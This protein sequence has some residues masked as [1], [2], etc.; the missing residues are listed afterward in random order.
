MGGGFVDP[1]DSGGFSSSPVSSEGMPGGLGGPSSPGG[2]F[3]CGCVENEEEQGA[4][5][6]SLAAPV[7]MNANGIVSRRMAIAENGRCRWIIMC[8]CPSMVRGI[9]P[10]NEL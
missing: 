2:N 3:L 8:C 5:A 6:P 4:G 7:A 9:S 10:V 1:P